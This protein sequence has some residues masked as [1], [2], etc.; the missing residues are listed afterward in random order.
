[1]QRIS[2]WRNIRHYRERL[3]SEADKLTRERLHRLLVAEEDRLGASRELIED[4]EREIA[5]S[6]TLIAE[7]RALI[8]SMEFEKRGDVKNERALL[9]GLAQ[10]QA[11]HEEYYRRLARRLTDEQTKLR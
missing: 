7:F 5:R 2:T 3:R 9:D 10:T 6:R 11:V 8:A 4:V 1:M